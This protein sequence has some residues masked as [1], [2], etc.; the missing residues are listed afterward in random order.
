MVRRAL[1]EGTLEERIA[2]VEALG[3]RGGVELGLELYQLLQG[4]EPALRDA[5][6]ESL[7]RL[8]AAGEDI[9]VPLNSL[10]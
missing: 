5:A 4:E 6:Y 3:W 10:S 9:P 8:K 2:A 1:S 7:W